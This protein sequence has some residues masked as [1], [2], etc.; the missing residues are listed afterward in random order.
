MV[1]KWIETHSVN[2][3]DL[4]CVRNRILCQY[5]LIGI[6]GKHEYTPE[7]GRT[8]RRGFRQL[9][10][11]SPVALWDSAV[12]TVSSGSMLQI[13]GGSSRSSR[14]LSPTILWILRI[15]TCYCFG[16]LIFACCV[17][18]I[19]WHSLSVRYSALCFLKFQLWTRSFILVRH[20]A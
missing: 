8:T 12:S 13:R 16:V 18:Q 14:Y 4:G 2:S 10:C 17:V 19:F 1:Q 5:V 20:C 3:C 9:F 11:T 6:S 15:R 7:S